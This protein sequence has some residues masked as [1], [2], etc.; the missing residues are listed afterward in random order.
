[1]TLTLADPGIA[2]TVVGAALTVRITDDDDNPTARAA[3]VKTPLAATAT[4]IGQL[5]AQAIGKRL[6]FD[7][8]STFNAAPAA[9]AGDVLRQSAFSLAHGNGG[10]NFWGSGGYA[11]TEGDHDGTAYDGDTTALHLGADTAWKNGLL[12]IAITR[13][14]SDMDFNGSDN[15]ET[16][17][18]SVHPYLTR[19]FAKTKLWTTIGHGTGD[20]ELKEPGAAAKT[21]VT[22]T[23]AALGATYAPLDNVHLNLAGQWSRAELE[24]AVLSNGNVLPAVDADALRISAA[25]ELSRRRDAWRSFLTVNLRHDSGDG[26]TGAAGDLG[27]GV[28]WQSPTVNLRLEGSKYLTGSGAEEERLTLAAR[29]TAG[30]LNLG[31]AVGMEDGLT[32]ANLLSGELQF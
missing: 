20:A 13:S 17:V 3:R 10:I 7:G 21:D 12:G 15:L 1:F 4:G 2:N 19:K 26:D 25:A 6:R 32:T 30:R 18:T 23:T 28:E 31:L 16:K 14:N 8:A 29:K 9:T 27:G 5:A 24:R 11:A 22:V